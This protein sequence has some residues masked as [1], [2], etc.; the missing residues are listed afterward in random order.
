MKVQFTL[1]TEALVEEFG[2]A[3]FY[4][5]VIVFLDFKLKQKN[6]FCTLI[7][8]HLGGIESNPTQV[9]FKQFSSKFKSCLLA[10]K[11]QFILE[12]E[13]SVKEFGKVKSDQEDF[14]CH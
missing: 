10:M 4:W 13:A 5:E 8:F 2:E 1:E 7:L 9:F 6:H 11:V 14:V 12:T 3:I